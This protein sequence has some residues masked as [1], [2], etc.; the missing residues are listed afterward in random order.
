M[1]LSVNQPMEI[2]LLITGSLLH[3]QEKHIKAIMYFLS[4]LSKEQGR[5]RC[6][7]KSVKKHFGDNVM[8]SACEVRKTA[9]T[10]GM[11]DIPNETKEAKIK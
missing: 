1:P 5:G 8:A 6:S 11:S 7:V 3:S 9:L 10:A 4:H 2:A